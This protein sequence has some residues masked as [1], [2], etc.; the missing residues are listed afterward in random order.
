MEKDTGIMDGLFHSYV[1]TGLFFRCIDS[2]TDKII[3]GKRSGRDL[4]FKK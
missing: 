4:K 3:Q 2:T 1:K